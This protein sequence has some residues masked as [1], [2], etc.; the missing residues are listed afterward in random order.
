MSDKISK[1]AKR[2]V[3]AGAAMPKKETPKLTPEQM[4]QEIRN[5]RAAGLFVSNMEFVDALLAQYDA[6][7]ERVISYNSRIKELERMLNDSEANE[8]SYAAELA[9]AKETID[10]LRKADT[11]LSVGEQPS[12]NE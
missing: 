11:P 4:I 5:C 7:A 1:T 3:A 8:M 9:K 12:E 10:Q 2:S 6:A